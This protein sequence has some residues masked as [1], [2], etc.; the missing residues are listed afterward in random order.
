MDTLVGNNGRDLMIGGQDADSLDGGNDD[1][2]EIGGATAYDANVAALDAILNEWAS[3]S[4]Y[5]IRI[6]NLLIGGGLSGGTC[7]RLGA[8]RTVFDDGVADTLT[9]GTGLDWFF[10]GIGDAITD[11]NTG[12]PET[13]S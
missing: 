12:G 1:D 10:Q 8:G 13:V 7:G 3:S 4:T 2:L 9:G 6:N 5:A 11:L